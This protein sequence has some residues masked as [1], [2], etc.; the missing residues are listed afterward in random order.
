MYLILARLLDVCRYNNDISRRADSIMAL[1]Y[2]TNV[3]KQDKTCT[4]G[5]REGETTHKHP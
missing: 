3:Q 5:E 1:F 2:L 4:T